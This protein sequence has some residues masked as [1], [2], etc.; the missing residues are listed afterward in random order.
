MTLFR[1]PTKL[2]GRVQSQL[3]SCL[4]CNAEQF[5]PTELLA[6]HR[7]HGI[8]PRRLRRI[9]LFESVVGRLQ[10]IL[11]Q[12]PKRISETVFNAKDRG[13]AI[14]EI[15][16]AV[17]QAGSG[18]DLDAATADGLEIAPRPAPLY[19][20]DDLDRVV[21]SEAVVPAGIEVNGL[22]RREYAYLAPGMSAPIRITTDPEYYE[23][24]LES[25]ELWS[26]GNPLF[27]ALEVI[28]DPGELPPN[29]SIDGLIDGAAAAAAKA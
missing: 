11:S 13:L 20:M 19:D 8:V 25:V 3:E 28:A 26:P 21:S 16:N 14:A 15:E 9:G 4:R 2:N 18:L 29:C 23:E 10:P 1:Q 24:N 27:P 17:E 7:L 5:P 22:S 6:L 12:L